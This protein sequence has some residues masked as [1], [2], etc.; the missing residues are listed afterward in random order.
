MRDFEAGERGGVLACALDQSVIGRAGEVDLAGTAHVAA[1][2]RVVVG[3]AEEL[4][5]QVPAPPGGIEHPGDAALQADFLA[6][7]SG[8]MAGGEVV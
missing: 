3:G 6:D 7:R 1:R 5:A 8:L 4:A 2:V